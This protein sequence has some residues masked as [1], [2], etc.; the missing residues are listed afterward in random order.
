MTTWEKMVYSVFSEVGMPT[1]VM[2]LECSAIFS[3]IT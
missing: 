2:K 1:R 3:A